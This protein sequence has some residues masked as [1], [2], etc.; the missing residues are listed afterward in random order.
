[1]HYGCCLFFFLH[2]HV[3]SL[4]CDAL[5]L[6]CGPSTPYVSLS[7]AKHTLY[8]PT[9]CTTAL[10][11]LELVTMLCGWGAPLNAVTNTNKRAI[12]LAQLS[13]TQNPYVLCSSLPLPMIL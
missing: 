8:L 2:V 12:D 4:R 6:R 13:T 3:L 5:S 7:N 9:R 11:N 10:G 1:M